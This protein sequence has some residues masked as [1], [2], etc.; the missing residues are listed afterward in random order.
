MYYRRYK[1]YLFFNKI[2][3]IKTKFR[4]GLDECKRLFKIAKRWDI[5]YVDAFDLIN[6]VEKVQST[7]KKIIPIKRSHSCCI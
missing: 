4:F 7:Y 6:N 2:Y 3:K 5:S 1:Q